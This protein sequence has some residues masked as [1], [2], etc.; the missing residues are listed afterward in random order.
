[1]MFLHSDVSSTLPPLVLRQSSLTLALFPLGPQTRP[2]QLV[3]GRTWKGTAFG[4]YKSRRDV[5][6]LVQKY[7]SGGTKLDDYITHEMNF[8]QVR[9]SHPST[10]NIAQA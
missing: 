3:T 8:D 10:S 7:M 1:M 6:G 2:F 9:C 4:G 5:P